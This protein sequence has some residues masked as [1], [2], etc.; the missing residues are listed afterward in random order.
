MDASE[1]SDKPRLFLAAPE[2][3]V[4]FSSKSLPNGGIATEIVRQAF[5]QAGYEIDVV[6]VPWPRALENAKKGIYDGVLGAWYT[7]ERTQ[8]FTYSLPFFK[9]EIVFFK[10]KDERIAYKSLKDLKP[11]RIGVA[12]NAAPHE[13]LKS[14]LA[15]N[16]E[17]ANSGILSIKMLMGKR[18]NM[19]AEEKLSVIHLLNNN[20]P[21]W[22][23]TIEVMDPPLQINNLHVIISKKLPHHQNITADFNAGLQKIL[24]EGWIENL[25]KQRGFE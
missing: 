6:W 1:K 3:F 4:P 2:D 25:R 15:A 7:E 20:F 23:N 10:R 19:I 17:V 24:S 13:L 11:Y 22:R 8:F 14:E 16:L 12:K 21:Q 18:F 5:L 9:N